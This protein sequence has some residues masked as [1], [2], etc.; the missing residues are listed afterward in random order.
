MRIDGHDD[1]RWLSPDRAKRAPGYRVGASVASVFIGVVI[2]DM[3]LP[4]PSPCTMQLT[5]TALCWD[6]HN[7]PD[8]NASL[9][10]EG[11]SWCP[12]HSE[13]WQSLGKHHATDAGAV[14]HLCLRRSLW[15]F[16]HHEPTLPSLPVRLIVVQ[17]RDQLAELLQGFEWEPGVRKPVALPD[18][19]ACTKVPFSR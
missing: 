5:G 4:G 7:R 3:R 18:N 1:I 2:T 11:L 13:D 17:C 15:A 9:N 14:V 19:L 10:R 16:R 12:A 8:R 6:I